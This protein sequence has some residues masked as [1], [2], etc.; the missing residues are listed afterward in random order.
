MSTGPKNNRTFRSSSNHF[1]ERQSN[2][3]RITVP[4]HLRR[5]TGVK[6]QPNRIQNRIRNI[7]NRYNEQVQSY[8]QLQNSSIFKPQINRNVQNPNNFNQNRDMKVRVSMTNGGVKSD[9]R[10]LEQETV[11]ESQQYNQSRRTGEL[12]KAEP[13]ENFQTADD[14]VDL[15][16]SDD[17]SDINNADDIIEDLD[18][19]DEEESSSEPIIEVPDDVDL[20]KTATS[21]YTTTAL[22]TGNYPTINPYIPT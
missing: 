21:N 5:N 14:I 18:S 9:S 6:N 7:K 15:F 20:N 4:E 3:A 11:V 22:R 8:S 13:T 10:S 1:N 2:I 16:S 12:V 19:S 17:E